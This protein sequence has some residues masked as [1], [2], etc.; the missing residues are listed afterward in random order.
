ML[1]LTLFIQSLS[2][3]N[4]DQSH[5][6]WSKYLCPTEFEWIRSWS[7]W[8]GTTGVICSWIGKNCYIRLCLLSNIYKYKPFSTKLG[9]NEY[10]HR[11]Q[12]SL[13]MGQVIPDQWVLSALEIEKLNFSSLFAIYFH[14]YPV[15]F[16]TQVSDIGPS[17]SSCWRNQILSKILKRTMGGTF[18]WN[19]IK[20]WLVVSEKKMFKEKVNA[21]KDGWTD[22][23]QTT[24]AGLLPVDLKRLVNQV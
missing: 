18:L 5:Q 9:H 20:I 16:S 3:A 2:S 13:I 8:T 6:T 12:M 22:T 23:R 7:D 21:W 24:L 1:Y 14:C 4:I 17:W 10:E 11:S 19:F 15:L